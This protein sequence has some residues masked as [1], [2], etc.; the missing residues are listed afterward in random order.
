MVSSTLKLFS[1]ISRLPFHSSTYLFFLTLYRAGMGPPAIPRRA[2]AFLIYF[3]NEK[4]K[5][6]QHTKIR[7][8]EEHAAQVLPVSGSKRSIANTTLRT[9]ITTHCCTRF[10]RKPLR[11]NIDSLMFCQERNTRPVG[12]GK[13]LSTSYC[14]WNRISSVCPL[15]VV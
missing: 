7:K 12:A 3:Y 14:S 9:R 4:E 2:I 10:A 5:R 15:L 13:R 6:R 1:V 8:R 11:P